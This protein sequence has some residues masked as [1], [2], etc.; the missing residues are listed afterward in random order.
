MAEGERPQERPER[1]RGPGAGEQPAHRAVPQQGHVID[2]VRTRDHPRDQ[3]G[4]LQVGV[5]AA[6][7]VDPNVLPDQVLQAGAC[8]ELQDRPEARTRHEV[9]VV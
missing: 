2:A 5:A 6:G 1:G 9:G 4:D 8:R 7:L 3:P